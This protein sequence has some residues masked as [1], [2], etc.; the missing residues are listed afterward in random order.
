MHMTQ[1]A[2]VQVGHFHLSVCVLTPMHSG[3]KHWL[4]AQQRIIGLPLSG[5]RHPFPHG[6]FDV[7]YKKIF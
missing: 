3:W 4:Q 7:I 2:S 5:A 6:T 1:S